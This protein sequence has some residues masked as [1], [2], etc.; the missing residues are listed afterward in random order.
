MTGNRLASPAS[1]QRCATNHGALLDRCAIAAVAVTAVLGPVTAL[2]GPAGERFDPSQVSVGRSGTTTTI[3]QS[4]DKAVI[5]WRSFDVGRSEHVHFAQPGRGSW[6]LN[7]VND[8]KPSQIDGRITAPGNIII[9]NPQGVAFSGSARV[10]VGG[11]VATATGITEDNF[12]KGRLVFDQPGAP[13]ARVSNEG[14]I[15][16]AEAGLAALV[17]P[18]VRNAG[19]I[20]ARLGTVV[21]AAGDKATIDLHGDGLVKVAVDGMT[22]RAIESTGTVI[23]DGGRVVMTTAAVSGVVDGTINLGGLVRARSVASRNGTVSLEGGEVA[24]TGRIDATGEG[25]GGTVEIAARDATMARRARIDASAGAVGDGGKVTV[26]ATRTAR[27]DGAI[28]AKGGTTR[29]DGGLVETSGHQDLAIGE[30][31]SVDASATDGANGRWLIDPTNIVIANAG[32]T[33]TPAIVAGT[34]NTGTDMTLTTAAPGPDVG[35]ITLESALSWSGGGDLMLIADND[36]VFN[37]TLTS[38]GTGA[39]PGNLRLTAANDIILNANV[40]VTGAGSMTLEAGNVFALQGSGGTTLSTT[41]GGL[42]ITAAG[43]VRLSGAQSRTVSTTTGDLSISTGGSVSLTG[44]G[45]RTVRSTAGGDVSISAGSSVTLDG[46]GNRT[47]SSTTGALTIDA[48]TSV[49]LGGSGATTVSTTAGDLAIHADD[50]VSLTGSNTRMIRSTTG[51]GVSIS[52]G[53]SVTLG[54]AGNQTVS[55]TTGTLR[56]DAG[57]SVTL[58]GSGNHTVSTTIGALAI[59]AG[60]SVTLDGTGSRAVSTGSGSLSITA[61]AGDIAMLRGTSGS[62]SIRSTSGRVTLDAARDLLLRGGTAANTSASARANGNTLDIRVGRDIVLISGAASNSF[63]ELFQG[64][65]GSLDLVAGREIRL[66]RSAASTA[67]LDTGTANLSLEAPTITLNGE[68]LQGGNLTFDGAVVLTAPNPLVLPSNGSFMLASGASLTSTG[69]LTVRATGAG[70]I[71]FAGDNAI[72]GPGAATFRSVNGDITF[73]G[74]VTRSGDLAASASGA[75]DVRVTLTDVLTATGSI[76]FTSS[77]TGVVDIAGSVAGSGVALTSGTGAVIVGGDIAS[78]TGLALSSTAGGNITALSGSQLTA[79]GALSAMTAG[80]IDLAGTAGGSTVTATAGTSLGVAGELASTTGAVTLTSGTGPL[81]VA[82]T[83]RVTSAAELSLQSTGGGAVSAAAGGLVVAIGP[84]VASSSG[85]VDLLGSITASAV[86]A[87]AGDTLSVAG[88]IT[89]GDSTSLTTTGAGALT[90]TGTAAV[91]SAGSTM[92]A[93]TGTGD[94]VVASGATLTSAGAVSATSTAGAVDLSGA[95]GGPT[96]FARSATGLTVGDGITATE[97][98]DSIVLVAG[99]SFTNS[100][101]AG[102]LDPGPGRFLV[103]VPEPS[104]TLGTR[105][106][107]ADYNLYGRTFAANPPGSLPAGNRLVFASTPTLTLTADPA[108][109]VQGT[110]NPSFTYTATGLQPGDVVATAVAPGDLVLSTPATVASPIGDYAIDIAATASDQGYLLSLVDGIL[111]VTAAPPIPPPP[112]PLPNVTVDALRADYT[113]EAN[114]AE[115]TGL[116]PTGPFPRV[117]VVDNR[118]QPIEGARFLIESL[119][120][121]AGPEDADDELRLEAR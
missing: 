34:L 106:G 27:V 88:P 114:V 58:G 37:Q 56:I 89:S 108:S 21:L 26:V 70:A 63:T 120:P 111:T 43:A 118:L 100:G 71:T 67:R 13:G 101:G 83:G 121:G 31:A 78:A 2:A 36:I 90:L 82:A 97:G 75:G 3:T 66:A 95:V 45:T 22:R 59:I 40:S 54:A 44:S 84:F 52:A 94:V 12:R 6:T 69:P 99:T 113:F 103:Y 61:A 92:L 57:T 49:T 50:A 112:E 19:L 46:S 14:R 9:M 38:S 65:A 7:R 23:A 81:A 68:L 41:S 104:V 116:D 105:P 73:A 29:G 91:S 96:V 39:N 20:E 85:T 25:S 17:A 98:G 1:V 18:T 117:L 72:D 87:S 33:I 16:V 53:T 60:T 15:T 79:T 51:G 48:G 62:G 115:A 32:G 4:T 86:T 76:D 8:V 55:A 30:T 93:A 109:R 107:P 47:I 77:G 110:A 64:G 74:A 5:D 119:A 42:S 102:V 24:L 28:R 80:A 35:S 11:M 10:D